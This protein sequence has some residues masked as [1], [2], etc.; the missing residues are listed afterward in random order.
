M[1]QIQIKSSFLIDIRQTREYS[2]FMQKMGWQVE[3]VDKDC[4]MFIKKLPL[5]PFS[6]AKILKPQN[7]INFE[8]LKRLIKK[9]KILFTKIHP[10]LSHKN[11]NLTTYPDFIEDSRQSRNN[12]Q[13]TNP[14]IPTKTIWL[15][16]TKTENELLKNMKPKTRYNIRLAQKNNLNIQV[17]NGKQITNSQL[18]SFYSLWI[19]NKPHD[20]IFKP[21]FNELKY[22]VQSFGN[23]CFF[24]FIYPQLSITNPQLLSGALIL[25][26][27]NMSFYWHNCSSLQGKK[28]FAP[29]LCIWQALKESKKRGLKVFDFEGIYDERFHKSFKSWQGFTRF[30]KGF[31]GEEIEF[32]KPYLVLILKK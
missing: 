22:L 3:I 32:S 16:L 12:L 2:L 24:I 19:K 20:I 18:K 30:K 23:K 8:L 29:S 11:P 14:L 15:D 1:A 7:S 10:F 26:S 25:C 31:R 13:L 17:I 27:A 9:Y 4:Q 28:L 6:I 21:S 5:L